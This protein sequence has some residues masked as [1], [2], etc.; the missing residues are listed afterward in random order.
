[1]VIFSGFFYIQKIG[2]KHLWYVMDYIISGPDKSFFKSKKEDIADELEC[3]G[4]NTNHL[5]KTEL[6]Q[7]FQERLEGLQRPPTL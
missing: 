3:R 4:I 1:M 7:V 6:Q 5:N 2:D